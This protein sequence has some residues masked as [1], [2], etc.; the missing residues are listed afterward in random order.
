MR[1]GK[2]PGEAAPSSSTDQHQPKVEF[3][4]KESWLDK[5][6]PRSI[7]KDVWQKRWVVLA[8]GEMCYYKDPDSSPLGV[9]PLSHVEKISGIGNRVILSM[10]PQYSSREWKWRADSAQEAEKWRDALEAARAAASSAS[11]I[12]SRYSETDGKYWKRLDPTFKV[13]SLVAGRSHRGS[14][15][16]GADASD[17]A[18]T[19]Q[20]LAPVGEVMEIEDASA[21]RWARKKGP[22]QADRSKELLYMEGMLTK[23]NKRLGQTERFYVLNGNKMSG[24]KNARQEERVSTW[25]MEQLTSI[26]VVKADGRATLLLELNGVEEYELVGQEEE[27]RR[28]GAKLAAAHV[29]FGGILNISDLLHG[30][31]KKSALYKQLEAQGSGQQS[32][33]I[34]DLWCSNYDD[35]AGKDLK[36]FMDAASSL[37]SGLL[38]QMEAQLLPG[39]DI[40]KQAMQTLHDCLYGVVVHF[41]DDWN[42]Q[43]PAHIV[44]LLDWLASYYVR[45]KRMGSGELYPDILNLPVAKQMIDLLCPFVSGPML[46]PKGNSKFTKRWFSMKGSHIKMFESSEQEE[47]GTPPLQ[48][49]SLSKVVSVEREGKI[50]KLFF[51]KELTA[52]NTSAA[53]PASDPSSN[54][55]P[56]GFVSDLVKR[57]GSEREEDKLPFDCKRPFPGYE[58][59]E[60]M[61]SITDLSYKV[62]RRDASQGLGLSLMHS[63]S[64]ARLDG[65]SDWD[66]DVD[67]VFSGE[68]V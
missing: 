33:T 38:N 57:L 17:A 28:W 3:L 8:E 45:L 62:K 51:P 36:T 66:E 14:T 11:E 7:L 4:K 56:P 18:A 41:I 24:Y 21:P 43:S 13:Q 27:I 53:S 23:V 58:L 30:P 50:I 1:R 5:L 44:A 16:P 63:G 60:W 2:P 35:K 9:V 68:L 48:N 15:A 55:F 67:Y 10:L 42:V 39:T 22:S 64:V 49:I 40:T 65:G 31:T 32:G 29:Q 6:S 46:L 52:K 59:V 34:I 47:H 61:C 25:F 26:D 54:R 37:D 19:G 12:V 20:A